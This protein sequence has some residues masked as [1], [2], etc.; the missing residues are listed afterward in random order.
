MSHYSKNQV[1]NQGR[2]YNKI[3]E[4]PSDTLCKYVDN[5]MAVTDTPVIFINK[6]P[7][8]LVVLQEL[9]FSNGTVRTA[10]QLKAKGKLFLDSTTVQDGDI[11]YFQ[12][13]PNHNGHTLSSYTNPKFA[14]TS[15]AI[16]KRHGAIIVGNVSSVVNMYRRFLFSGADVSSINLHNLLPWPLI[17][18]LEDTPV[19]YLDRNVDLGDSN[20]HGDLTVTPTIYF[21][22]MGRG[23]NLGTTFG[24]YIDNKDGTFPIES[25]CQKKSQ[26]VFGEGGIPDNSP[27]FKAIYLYNF[28][29]SDI[30]M[31][32]IFIGDVS[33]TIDKKNLTSATPS[34]YPQNTTGRSIYRIGENA[35]FSKEGRIL[36]KNS[37][38]ADLRR[39]PLGSTRDRVG[40][41]AVRS[42][43]PSARY[44]KLSG[45]NVT[46]LCG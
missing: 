40:N 23:L 11:F 45:E 42:T 28:V 17:I 13:V 6:L 4:Y 27:L 37:P 2:T 43:V 39:T 38:K 20:H 18:T 34:P 26:G 1:G 22:N 8:N 46:M 14:C 29:L 9:R 33:P 19:A 24:V 41:S 15:I 5:A 31:D 12:Y 32:H 30:D 3:T 7:I 36:E 10:G 25:S 35:P 21:D 44:K 16:T